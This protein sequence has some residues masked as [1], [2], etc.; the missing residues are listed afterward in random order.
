MPEILIHLLHADQHQ[1][2]E[3]L[4]QEF[5]ADLVRDLLSKGFLK[6]QEGCVYLTD[7]GHK[8]ARNVQWDFVE[9]P[10]LPPPSQVMV[11][12][13]ADDPIGEPLFMTLLQDTYPSDP[14]LITVS[15]GMTKCFGHFK[16][17]LTI[18]NT[19]P[20]AGSCQDQFCSLLTTIKEESPENIQ[21]ILNDFKEEP[22]KKDT[23]K[24][25]QL[26]AVVSSVCF[27]CKKEI[28][29]G[30]AVFFVPS[31]GLQHLSC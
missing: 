1:T 17:D 28:P 11:S 19:C 25:T 10:S 5:D 12:D 31:K 24:K 18:C 15:A 20:I 9:R 6:T 4:L 22:I 21:E 7:I 14:Y 13:W 26:T 2:L 30:T 29:E 27:I 8:L 16:D 23:P 3:H